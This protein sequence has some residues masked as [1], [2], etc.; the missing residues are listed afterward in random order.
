[1]KRVDRRELKIKQWVSIKKTKS[2]SKDK[3]K[4]RASPNTREENI[5]I[6]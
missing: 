5:L 2:K 6:A 3:K 1:V 4:P